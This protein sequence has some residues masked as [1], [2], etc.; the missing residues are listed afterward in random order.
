MPCVC[1]GSS[2]SGRDIINIGVKGAQTS[3]VAI[4]FE[5]GVVRNHRALISCQ[6]I[7]RP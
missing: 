7:L 6:N 3:L 5:R 2:R 1:R 4:A